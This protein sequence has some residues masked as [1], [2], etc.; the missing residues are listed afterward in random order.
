[1]QGVPALT[2]GLMYRAAFVVALADGA[3]AALLAWRVGTDGLRRAP[4]EIAL[5]S[6]L[7][8]FGVWLTM[9][10]VYWAPVY[11]HVFPAWARW[12]VPPA[13]GVAFAGVAALW[14]HLALKVPGVAV[15][16]FVA[17]WCATGT[18]THAWAIY[19][20]GLLEKSPMLQELTPASAIVFATFEFGFYGCL[21]LTF[22]ALLRRSPRGRSLPTHDHPRP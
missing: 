4:R 12:L 21:I 16:A 1:M 18:L 6:G 2:P 5:V 8:W 14:R 15:P 3:Y 7:Y 22:A 13:Y 10:T 17:L 19:G 20:R 9:H 11:G